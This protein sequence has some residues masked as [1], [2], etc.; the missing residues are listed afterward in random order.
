MDMHE[1]LFVHAEEAAF[2]KCK[3]ARYTIASS[4]GGFIDDLWVR[5]L[6]ER[7]WMSSAAYRR[8]GEDCPK[9]TRGPA[10]YDFETPV[11]SGWAD[12][13]TAWE[14]ECNRCKPRLANPA[15]LMAA[16]CSLL[17]GCSIIC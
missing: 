15:Q 3:K 13:A 12:M 5:Y 9:G 14:F 11:V 1:D 16:F 8:E 10:V 6:E 4:D 2:L 7:E 17:H